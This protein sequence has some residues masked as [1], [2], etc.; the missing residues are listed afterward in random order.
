MSALS[1]R[2]FTHL[3]GAAAVAGFG[4]GRGGHAQARG[5]LELACDELEDPGARHQRTTARSLARAASVAASR[6]SIV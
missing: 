4:L 5:A 2:E 1:R 6:S 3:L